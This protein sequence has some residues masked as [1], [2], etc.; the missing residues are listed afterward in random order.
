MKMEGVTTGD[1]VLGI[2]H[3]KDRREVVRLVISIKKLQNKNDKNFLQTVLPHFI[4][5]LLKKK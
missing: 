3:A 5:M 1:T 4:F 2:R